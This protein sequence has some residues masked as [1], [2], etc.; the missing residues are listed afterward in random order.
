MLCVQR[1]V[2]EFDLYDWLKQIGDCVSFRPSIHAFIG[3]AFF[4]SDG[5]AQQYIYSIRQL[6]SYQHKFRS[7][8][9]F[10]EYIQA[11]KN[12]THE[13]ILKTTFV[14]QNDENPFFRSGFR[15]NQLV[16]SY[17]WLFK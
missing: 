13:S 9:E 2:H 10:T 12:I 3:F 1:L 17:I 5:T 11:F 15:P 6:C 8:S 7:K 16:C 4:V 14:S